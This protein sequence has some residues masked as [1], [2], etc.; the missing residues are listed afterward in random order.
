M[1]TMCLKYRQLLDYVIVNSCL[2][3]TTVQ[4]LDRHLSFYRTIIS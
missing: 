2:P 4:D 1:I 3:R